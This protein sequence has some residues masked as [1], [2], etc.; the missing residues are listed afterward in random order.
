MS[1]FIDDD[2]VLHINMQSLKILLSTII[3][4]ASCAA[5]T[6]ISQVG[7]FQPPIELSLP[8]L[9][10]ETA[11]QL[12]DV[13]GVIIGMNAEERHRGTISLAY[14]SMIELGLK[15]HDI[16]ILDVSTG[17]P[18]FPKSDTTSLA[19]VRYL[20]SHLSQIVEPWD[21]VIVFTTGHGVLSKGR[22][23]VVLNPSELMS[24]RELLASLD[25]IQ[26]ILGLAIFD[27][28]YWGPELHLNTCQWSTITVA[29]TLRESVG[30]AFS[31]GFWNSM[32]EGQGFIKSFERASSLDPA[33][34][35]GLNE[36]SFRVHV[37]ADENPSRNHDSV[38]TR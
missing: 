17:G 9:M 4:L 10:D 24:S 12:P 5:P 25:A 11:N 34:R 23:H 26:P 21:I 14:Q 32:R 16:F 7:S 37:C 38:S 15:R 13:F 36:P 20:L 22:P 3:A 18:T 1:F 31:R 27:Q 19:S 35:A 30:D 29:K 33:T 6:P 28:C 2:F 8:S